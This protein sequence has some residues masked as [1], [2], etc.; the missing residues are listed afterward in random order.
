[1]RDPKRMDLLTS[2]DVMG[3]PARMKKPT[4]STL[5][6]LMGESGLLRSRDLLRARIDRSALR[7]LTAEGVLERVTR[8]V[9]RLAEAP[10]SE[11]HTVAAVCTR[12]PQAVVCLL[13]ALQMHQLTTQL[14]RQVWIA[15]DE[16]ARRPQLRDLPVRVVRFSGAALTEGV[17]T[18]R[19]DG[20]VV[21][22]YR[23]AKTVADCFKYRN[24][25]GLDVAIEALREFRRRHPRQGDELLAAARV[26]RVLGVMR[27]Y[28]EAMA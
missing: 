2:P 7:R 9:Y 4:R 5:L 25:I 3:Q 19:I 10:V 26:C 16:K 15:L 17:E 24:K 21:R 20:V 18:R 22:I 14:P 28:L 12:V 23:P 27:P 6:A 11:G 13:T 8:G 1:M